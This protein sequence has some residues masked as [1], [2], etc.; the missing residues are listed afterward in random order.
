[1]DAATP[2]TIGI[3][4]KNRPDS[5]VRC[6]RS[7]TMIRSLVGEVIIIDDGSSPALEP[8]I[9]PQLSDAEQQG[10]TFVRF[11]VSG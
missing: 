8:V 5:L 2:V 7:L 4:T 11:E 10:L 9:R 6:L 3:A 1:M